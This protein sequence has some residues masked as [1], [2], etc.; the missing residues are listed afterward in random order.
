MRTTMMTIVTKTPVTTTTTQ[1]DNWLAQATRKLAEDSAAQVRAEICEHYD[2]AHEA[3]MAAGATTD[4]ADQKAV[5]A[6]GSPKTA[7]CQYRKVLLTSAE[8]SL[9]REGN[10]EARTVCSR[11]WL[12]VLILTVPLAALVAGAIMLFRGQ[13]TGAR[14]ALAGGAVTGFL[15]GVPV[16]PVYPPSRGRMYRAL[17]WAVMIGMLAFTF[18]A[19]A[20]TW[21]WLL[22]SC[23]WPFFWT[24][25]IRESIRH[26]IPIAN[27]P[28]HLYL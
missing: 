21:S 25:Y 2:A 4:E 15:L 13:M 7:N 20:L 11:P 5:S 10:W 18:G 3:A 17:I 9:L 16:L 14:I 28:K 23:F 26:K 19:A 8:A 27:W 24:E 12:K 6:L 22:I 1:L